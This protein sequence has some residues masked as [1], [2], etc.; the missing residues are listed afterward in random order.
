MA[1]IL[2]ADRAAAIGAAD[3]RHARGDMYGDPLYVVLRQ[4]YLA[5]VHANAHWN[6]KPVQWR[7]T[8][9][10]Q[11]V[12]TCPT[13]AAAPRRPLSSEPEAITPPR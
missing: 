10:R 2:F 13:I 5:S 12:R 9:W 6:V 8:G 1:G 7:R 3:V 4:L 11:A